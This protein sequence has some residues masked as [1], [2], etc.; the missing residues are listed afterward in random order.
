VTRHRTTGPVRALAALLLPLAAACGSDTQPGT[1]P[2]GGGTTVINRT[3]SAFKQPAPNLTPDELDLHAR[4]DL[5]FGATFV[6]AGGPVGLNPGL[7]PVFNHNGCGSC[8]VNDGRGLP[9]ASQGPLGSPLLLRVSL[10]TGTPE[11]PGG[12]VPVPGLG[13]QIEDHAVV[14]EDPEA[15]V[16]IAW[17]DTVGAYGDG[18]PY[19]LRRPVFTVTLAD[20]SPL[21]ADVLVSPRVPP[22]VFGL[23]LLE[24]VP[25]ADL[26]RMED[27]SDADGDGISGRRNRVWDVDAGETV[28][29]R[30]GWKANQPNLLQQAAGA[31]LGDIGVTSPMFPETDGS[32]EIDLDTLL[33]VTFYTQTLGVPARAD[34]DDPEVQAGEA[35]FSAIGCAGCHRPTLHTGDHAVPALVDQTIHPYTDLLLHDMGDGLADGRPDFE[36]DGREWRTAPLWGLGLVPT[37]LGDTA[38]LHD[39]RARTIP[40]AILWH[41]GEAEAA[42]EAFRTMGA[43]DRERLLAFLRSL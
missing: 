38:Y 28:T 15:T 39:G 5:A 7:G 27:P 2:A 22:P 31:Y 17:Q 35:L 40:E 20:G 21:P 19:T 43:T 34:P 33:A 12:P 3:S 9:V 14:G 6:T 24:A 1:G 42:R 11:V 16:A 25:D 13:T 10:P 37:V 8:H 30:F 18:T 29:G 23:G 26:A 32:S 36:A 4:G 41:G